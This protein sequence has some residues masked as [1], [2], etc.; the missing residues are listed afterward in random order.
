M[1]FRVC[2][3]DFEVTETKVPS[4]HKT[5]FYVLY[6]GENKKLKF[7]YTD[8]LFYDL[9]CIMSLNVEEE[10]AIIINRETRTELFCMI[11]NISDFKEF[12]KSPSSEF[13]NEFRV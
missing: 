9:S 13:K 4:E 6:E 5:C 3:Q 2:G 12:L 1:I 11:H 10:L 7:E 8:E